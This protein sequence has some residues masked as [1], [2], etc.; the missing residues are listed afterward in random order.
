MVY[1][2]PHGHFFMPSFLILLD[3]WGPF[4]G[5]FFQMSLLPEVLC[6][7][8]VEV[9]QIGAKPSISSQGAEVE[10]MKPYKRVT[11]FGGSWPNCYFGGRILQPRI[12]RWLG[13]LVQR[14]KRL[15]KNMELQWSVDVWPLKTEGL[16]LKCSRF[17][18]K[19]HHHLPTLQ[20][21][22]RS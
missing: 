11:L 19:E 4:W 12:V 22:G 8:H 20:L 18:N 21:W 17:F 5:H 10:A 15:K 13:S 16:E 3:L 1:I 6:W 7:Q 9:H 2:R 14:E